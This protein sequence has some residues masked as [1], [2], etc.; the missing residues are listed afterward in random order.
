MTPFSIAP[1]LDKGVQYDPYANVL[2]AKIRA[3]RYV[4]ELWD[5]NS[6][7]LD[8]AD[9]IG[10]PAYRQ[11][12]AFK[13]RYELTPDERGEARRERERVRT[14]P[15][16]KTQREEARASRAA[17]KA[18][19][20][21]YWREWAEE[22]RREDQAWAE[23]QEQE[24]QERERR[25]REWAERGGELGM[26]ERDAILAGPWECANCLRPSIIMPMPMEA[27][28]RLTCPRCGR[29]AIA[30][31]AVLF[32]LVNHKARQEPAKAG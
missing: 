17:A 32:G 31:H 21:R 25:D 16:L 28:Y 3:G 26:A 6:F 4:P 2:V 9:R 18:E 24:R 11:A 1:L 13:S 22:R 10:S 27:K 23:R 20:E 19:T 12:A 7:Y 29:T 8:Y 15:V 5:C 30:E 14:D